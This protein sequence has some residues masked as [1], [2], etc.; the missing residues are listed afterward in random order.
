M[1]EI[2]TLV[3]LTPGFPKDESDSTCLP[4]RQFFLRSLKKNNHL[5]KIIV[6]AFQYPFISKTYCW[7]GIEVISFNGR[8]KVKLNKVLVWYRVWQT[9]KKLK[10]ENNIIGILNFWLGECAL[11]GNYFS[12]KNKIKQYTWILGQDARKGN[13]YFRLIKP[14]AENLIALSDFIADEFCKNYLIRPKYIIPVGIDTSIFSSEK[15]ERTIDVMGTGSLIT[16]KQY[17]IFISVI[18]SLTSFYPDITAVIC[19]KGSE[20]ENLLQQIEALHLQNN[21]TLMDEIPH[22]EVL[23]LMQQ[24][25][26]FLHPSSYEGFGAV[27]S[28]ALF[29]GCHVVSFIKPMQINIHHWH[30]VKTS[31]EVIGCIKD[32][33][34][35]N[36]TDHEP[37]LPY[38]VDD[39]ARNVIQLF[40]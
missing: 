2:K 15:Q 33:L 28:E 37:V 12:K 29:A 7:H 32:I 10:K 26:I 16:L 34:L 21:V 5:L 24:S 13:K 25:K 40:T 38:S 8:N 39:T 6:L 35:N 3:V 23:I 27:C 31:V 20:K 19:G 4:E 11:I 9:L 36:S 30:I 1:K 14:K 17:N 18:K 22:S